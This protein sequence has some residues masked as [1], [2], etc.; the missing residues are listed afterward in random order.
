MLVIRALNNLCDV[1]EVAEMRG[2]V[3]LFTLECLLLR[4]QRK[5]LEL[6]RQDGCE[7]TDL[8]VLG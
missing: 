5:R 8:N 1:V 3:L 4:F 7:V 2:A 6:C